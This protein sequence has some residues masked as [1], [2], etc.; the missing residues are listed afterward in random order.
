[1]QAFAAQDG[2]TVANLTC[3]ASQSDTQNA[4]LLAM[5]LGSAAPTFNAGGGGGTPLGGGGGTP[6]YDVSHLQYATSFIDAQSARVQVTGFLRLSSGM[7][8]QTLP[9]N[10]SVPL[11]RE[12]NQWRVCAT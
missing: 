4:R 2:P 10:T 7:A 1:M 12:Q 6:V 11:I 5:A 8:S 9:M 3:R